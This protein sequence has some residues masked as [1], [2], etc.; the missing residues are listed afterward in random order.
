MTFS[1]KEMLCISCIAFIKIL[2][3][4]LNKVNCLFY[5]AISMIRASLMDL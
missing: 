2:T 4:L 5:S 1:F 3:Y